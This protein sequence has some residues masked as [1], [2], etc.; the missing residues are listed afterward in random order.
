MS[1]DWEWMRALVQGHWRRIYNYV[2]RVVLDRSRAERYS[3]DV[4]VRVSEVLRPPV[5]TTPREEEVALLRV[6]TAVLEERLPRQPELNFDILDETL[7]S[8]ATR[9]DVVRSLSDPQRDFLLWELKQGCMTAVVNCLPPGEREAFV[10]ATILKLTEDEASA[11]LEINP[12]AYKVRLSRARKKIGDYLAPRCE[13]VNPQNP[14]RCP[15][16]VGI[17]ISKGFIPP[18]GEISLR[19]NLPSYG[20][21]G[22]GPGNDDISLR[23]VTGVYGNLPDPEPPEALLVRLMTRFPE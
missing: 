13:H 21:Y 12:A 15:A 3:E 9:T 14:C 16:R 17:A 7:R 18:A 1:S 20:R 2:F 6:A 11:A 5:G 4:F 8:E 23:D 19:K 10:L 22:V